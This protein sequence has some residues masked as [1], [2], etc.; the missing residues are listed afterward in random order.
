[1]EMAIYQ[2]SKALSRAQSRQRRKKDGESG[3]FGGRRI[4]SALDARAGCAFGGLRRLGRGHIHGGAKD[5]REGVVGRAGAPTR[6]ELEN[7]G[8]RRRP[9]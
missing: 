8:G 6:T 4:P 3:S 2:A 9:P 5:W 7:D 1:L